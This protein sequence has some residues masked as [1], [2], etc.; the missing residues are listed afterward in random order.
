MSRIAVFVVL[1]A[2]SA[3]LVCQRTEP[4]AAQDKKDKQDKQDKQIAV[5]KQQLQQAEKQ[6]TTLKQDVTTLKDAN[7]K[8][9]TSNTKLQ[10]DNTRLQGLVKKGNPNVK[11]VN[12]LQT[13]IDGYRN[14]GLVH[15]VVLKLK[16]DS[17]N[18]EA[19]SVIDDTYAQL[20]KIK[21]VRG[22]WAGKPSGSG[23]L[24]TATTYTIALVFVFDD[25][26]G[27]KSYQT[28]PIHLK[29]VEKHLKLWETPLV[30]DFEP[31]P[32]LP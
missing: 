4:L 18:T 8:L 29:F 3:L 26:D 1:F 22:V 11:A 12:D 23:T 5:L 20:M 9:Q 21:T 30:F 32:P 14:A 27:L 25:S 15:V 24:D 6:I 7:T 19:Q 2:A 31:K 16:A 10:A 28:D 17:A 13:I